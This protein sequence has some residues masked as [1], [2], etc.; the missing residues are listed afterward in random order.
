MKNFLQS[1][2]IVFALALCALCAWQWNNQVDLHKSLTSLTQSNY[3]LTVSIRGYTNSIGVLDRQVA[4]MDARLTELRDT[5]KSNNASSFT[6]QEENARLKTFSEQYSNAVV[7]LQNQIKQA[8]D[9][10]R[11]QNESVKGL[12]A[13]RD[14]YVK[15]LNESIKERNEIVGK[16]NEL[17]KQFEE[18]Q[19]AATKKAQPAK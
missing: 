4:Q 1:L 6:L 12:V 3:D 5:I 10:I 8:N 2:L 11:R 14:E 18:Y 19:A 16:Y 7:A 13:E 17:V 15:R 9:S